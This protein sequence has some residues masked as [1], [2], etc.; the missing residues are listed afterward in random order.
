MGILCGAADVCVVR[1]RRGSPGSRA[2]YRSTHSLP[3]LT[4]SSSSTPLCR[5]QW[6]QAV[7]NGTVNQAAATPSYDVSSKAPAGETQSIGELMAFSGPAPELIN[8]RLAM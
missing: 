5:L 2:N 3:H 8:G 7:A 4:P 6:K 1:R